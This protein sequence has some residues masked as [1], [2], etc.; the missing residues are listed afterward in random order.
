MIKGIV[1]V[2]GGL[3]SLVT[4]A[5]A[6]SECDELYFLHLNYGQKTEKRELVAFHKI[7]KHYHPE[8]DLIV[9]ISY[10][11]QIGGSSLIDKKLA[12]KDSANSDAVPDTYV[13]F[14]NAHLLAIAVSWAEKIAADRIYIGAVEEDSAGYPDCRESFYQAFQTAVN[15]GTKDITNVKIITP[16]IHKNKAEIVRI[17]KNLTAPFQFSWSCYRE[18]KIACG[19]CDSCVLRIRGFKKAGIK[20]PISYQIK[21]NWNE[22]E[23]KNV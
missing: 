6:N 10:L 4:A 2:S 22:T 1:L 13:P 19:T 23:G 15:T 18:N 3:D 8:T 7:V 14:R 5:I 9:D 11:K 20:D 17:G 21:I 16:L 12:I